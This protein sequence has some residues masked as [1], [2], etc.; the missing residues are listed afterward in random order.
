VLIFLIGFMGSGKSTAGRML[1]ARLGYEFADLDKLIEEHEKMAITEIFALRGE[2]YFREVE[3]RVLGTVLDRSGMVVACGGGTPCFYDNMQK[4][5]LSGLTIYLKASTTVLAR[6]LSGKVSKRPLV[7][8]LEGD[9]LRSHLQKLLSGREGWYRQSHII[10]PADKI[11][12]DALVD[13]T[14]SHLNPRK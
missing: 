14:A 4:M 3:S 11:D 12:I 10:F 8:G 5:K 1:A 6:R 13:I 2:D 9:E 7:A